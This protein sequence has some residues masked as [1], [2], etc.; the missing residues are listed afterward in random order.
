V[1][2]VQ[3]RRALL[4]LVYHHDPSSRFQ[5]LAQVLRVSTQLAERIGLEQVVDRRLW[6]RVADQRALA[7]LAGPEE[8]DRALADESAQIQAPAVHISSSFADLHA[9]HQLRR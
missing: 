7:G 2:L 6:K 5:R 9:I 4:D 1:D 8:E 3:Q